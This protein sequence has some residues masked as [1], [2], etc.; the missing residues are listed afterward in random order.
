MPKSESGERTVPL[1]PLVLNT[2]REWKLACPK[3]ELGLGF[4]RRAID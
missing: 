3:S 2:L 4:L 1:P